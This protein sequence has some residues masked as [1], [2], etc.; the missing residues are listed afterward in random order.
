MDFGLT[1]FPALA[2]QDKSPRQYYEDC[3]TLA[4][5]ADLLGCE[6]VQVVEHTDINPAMD[7]A[8]REA[9]AAASALKLVGTPDAVADEIAYLAGPGG[10]SITAQRVEDSGGSVCASLSRMLEPHRQV[11]IATL[12]SCSPRKKPLGPR[13]DRRVRGA[14]GDRLPTSQ[15]AP[16]DYAVKRHRK[17]I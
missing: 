13:H 4:A 5:D 17:G 8:S 12:F 10:R 9:M 16:K 2:D 1:S 7:P 15:H 6:H 14:D 11:R 3:L